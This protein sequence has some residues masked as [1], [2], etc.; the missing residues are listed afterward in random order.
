MNNS[1]FWCNKQTPDY[2]TCNN[3]YEYNHLEKLVLNL[4]VQMS[5]CIYI[6]HGTA[7]QTKQ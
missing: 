4:N 7:G 3:I 5:S 2:N 1:H 6:K